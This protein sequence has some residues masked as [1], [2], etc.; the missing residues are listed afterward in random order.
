MG[1]K[2]KQAPRTK[3]N[4][5]P[6][7]SSR[8]AELLGSSTPIFVGFS[9]QTDGGGLVPFA[10]GFASAEQ[11][12]DSFDAAIS[13]QTQIIL[14]KLSKKDP[15]TKKKALQELHELIEQSDVEVLKNILPLWP[16]YYLNLA[17]DPEHTVR[18]QTQTVLQLLMAKC[19]KAM[20]PY[21][22]LLV[23]VWLG[24]R[25]D[26]YAPAASIASQSFRDTF[27]G[28]ANR[29]REVCMHCQVEILEYA[30]RNL[31]F[32]TAATLSIGKSLTPEDA[33]QKYQRV[34]ISSLKLLSFFM[35]QTAQ[36]EELS[37]VKEGFGTL[38]AHQKFWSFAKHKVPAIKA[39]WFEC[40]YHILQSVALL[41]VITPQKT[42]LTNLCFQFI[43]DADPVVAPHIWG[44]VLLL[45]SNYVDWF[46]PLNI[47]K[48]LLPKLSSLLQNGFNR[49][50]QAI[51]PNLL[52][53]LSKVTQA[54]LQDLDIYDFYQRFF[55]DMKLA[56]TKKF[57]P[58][59]SKSDCIVIHNA[60]FEC[61]RFLMQQIN[62]N[63]QREQKEEEFSFSLLDNNVLEPIA[64]LLKSDSTHVKIF[65]QHSSALVAFWDRQIN[66]RL[67]NGDL[68][69]KLLNKFWIRIFELVTQ[70]LSAEEVNEQL[71]GH[72]LL[73]VQDLHMANPSLE[74]PSVKFV[75]GPNEKIE[76]S[77]PTTP[78]KKAQEA[79][80]FIQK[81]LKQ[82][83]IKLVRICLDKANKGSG[84][85]TSSSRYIEQIRTLTKMFNDA[86]FYKSL[87]DDG[88]LASALNKFV[89]LLGQ[90][91][92]QACES[93]V[94][95]VFEI[96][97]LLETGKRFEYIENTLMK[98]PQHGVQNLL[99][100]RLLS[101]PLCAEAAVR[102]ML[103][104]P[105]T[106]EMIAR[107]AEE[108]VVDNDR[109]KLNLLHKCFFQTD[110]GDILINAKTV[111]KILLSM[112]GPL[113]QP[114]VDD[115][116]E[117]CGSFI[118]QI[119]PVICSNNNSSLHVRQHIFLK[120]FKFSLE[121]RPEDYLSEDTLWEITTCWQDGLSSKDIE[122]DDD[123]LKCCAGIV[124]ELANSAEL[125]AD[126]LDG[127]AEAMA[128][129]VICSTE[130][131]E[132]EYKRLERIDET[133]TA[134]LETP[135]KT[136]DKV[137]QFEN[138]CVLLEALHGSVTAGVPFENACL[139]RNEILP[140]LQRSTLNFSTIY[141]LV[142]QFPPP[143]DTNDPEDELTEDYCD[144]NADVLK[145]WNEPLIAEL[146]Q[147]IRVAGTAEC[148]LE[149]SVLQS[150]TEELV[151]ILSEKV[152]SFMGNSSDLVAIV[153][154]RLQQAAVQQSSV[155]DC[156][157][158]SYLRFC[159][160]YAAF[161]ESA[162]ILLHEDLSE[163]LVTQG[164]LKT[165]V[166]ALQFLLP[167][168]SQK[169]ITLSSAIMGTEPPEIWVKAAV[170]HALL[171]N[172]FEGDVNEQT[173]R[174]IIVSA[175]QFMTS[176]GER[177]ASQKDL[178]HYNVEIQR[179]P[180][181]S[182]IN[183]VEFIKLLTEVLKRFP[184]E[185]SIKN[186]DAIRIGLSSWVLSVSKSI[187]QYQD[188]KTSLFIVAVYELFAALIDFI[189]SEKQKSSTE[190][191]KNMID[192]WDSLFAKEVNL[193]LF[194]SYYLLTHEVSVDPGFQACYEALLEQITPVIERLDYSFVYS[195]CKSNSNITLD[196]LCNFLFKQLYSVQHS[197]R[198]SAV[199]S[200]RQLTPHF[201]ADDIELNEKQS[202]SL[203][204]STTICKW[205]FLNRFEDYLTRYDALITK[206]L[207]EFTFKLS[208]LDDLEP[209]DRHN[210]L[211]YLFLW[212]CIINACAKSPVALRAVYTNWLNDNKY[213]ENFLHF[214]F[215]A[216]P[217]DILKN[218]G[219]KVHS[220]G[221]YKE[222]TWS[223]QKDRHLPLERYACHLYT[224]VL[225]KL[226]A[227]VRRW[228][229]ATQSR[230]KNFIDNLTTN[231]VSS[232]ICSEELKAIANR[233]EKH[234]NMQVTVHSSTRE[235]LAVYAIDEAR[236]E[237]VITLAPN[238]PLGAVKVECGKQIGGRASSR[239]VG[240]QLTIF[241][242]H[243]NGTIY[244]GL[245]MWKN[246]LDKKF[247]G[248]EECYV[249]YTVIHQET[250]QLPKLTCKTCKKKFH[251]P[252]LYKWFTTS[253]KSTCPICRNV[254]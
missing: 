11:M 54:S 220:N 161:E 56:V 53:F 164:A 250:C 141:K 16:K 81:E 127:M 26:T 121:H 65:F 209:I 70:D 229:N 198:L 75:E 134:L 223:Q 93:V 213:E 191:L 94:E 25:F 1:G 159:P 245:T 112:C 97:P 30:T 85:G 15:M 21:L 125:K 96:L 48:T 239:N 204:A 216:M 74:S 130:N 6:S 168:L 226:P 9:A 116:V 182:V 188:P 95:I 104:G 28:N 193:V 63:K 234:E 230:Q 5:K 238:Y 176:I 243:Q 144:P 196:H 136:T 155:I 171:L 67:D 201:V 7:S 113:E 111:D 100:H 8:T 248:V 84:S 222:L 35:G 195:F 214:L 92:C 145:K 71:L 137:Q 37:Q 203:D 154:E 253:S 122:I 235:V 10:P 254:F 140:L 72:V 133:L 107:I 162:S 115:A 64:W 61:L 189:R 152:Q 151:L 33:E 20:A 208:E 12:P 131:I 80:A 38:V 215:R 19:K 114:V 76:K 47:R 199:H 24:S 200:L 118:A 82:L 42:Q 197:V 244:D 163:N 73:L 187:A 202:E 186:W 90:L 34:I 247:E 175:V 153:K 251:G 150:S 50:A 185:L 46:V 43:D 77:E 217:V 91:S 232:L 205:H 174:N 178:L 242:T 210:A 240:M 221:V 110:T 252:C 87:T 139:S 106:C 3:N 79:A 41:D 142:Y 167:K 102:Q 194:K 212:D 138:H 126:T 146:L 143:Q 55:D 17:S 148:W 22:K 128:K 105:E 103:S 14:R 184:Y 149:M 241:L 109:E 66:N 119:M 246:N 86:A 190:L 99:L 62:N 49:N 219:A 231:Y 69:A 78:V 177:Q 45:Q 23:P 59:L 173:D 44:C 51:C 4:A 147:C 31:T 120:L 68:Y 27:A 124:E 228:W 101:Y 57:D 18:E 233:K 36:T 249:C 237:L 58:P 83:V 192:E 170:F 2:T 158:L 169:A 29:S 60:Y 236:M 225:R 108:V 172:N 227:V 165:Y 179:Q 89:S 211:S 40:I 224:E 39:A 32:H 135:L 13:P 156:R 180:Y 166:I 52:P 123:M 98:L 88:D 218:H 181:E 132:D 183:T 207:E 157:L 117:V 160:Q 129:F 206:Y